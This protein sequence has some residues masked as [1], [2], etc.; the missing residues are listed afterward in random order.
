M[1]PMRMWNLD[2]LVQPRFYHFTGKEKPW[3]GRMDPWRDFWPRY[4]AMQRERP[5]GELAVPLASAEEIAAS[6][7]HQTIERVKA[8]TV[9]SQRFNRA[10]AA[11]IESEKAALI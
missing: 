11:V 6:N 4:E 8:L 2:E 7:R 3:L 10:R 9:H 5:L 1:A